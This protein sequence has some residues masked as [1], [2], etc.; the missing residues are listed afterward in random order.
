[1]EKKR[2]FIIAE[3]GVNH[4]GNLKYAKKLIQANQKSPE[5]ITTKLQII[6]PVESYAKNTKSYKIFNKNLLKF[7]ELKILS[8]YAKDQKILLFATLEIFLVLGLSKN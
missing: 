7:D 2:T 6:N 8:K 5:Q 1:M 3:I 4:N